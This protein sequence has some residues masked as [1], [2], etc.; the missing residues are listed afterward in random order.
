M[1]SI[2]TKTFAGVTSVTAILATTIVALDLPTLLN[3]TGLQVEGL[4]FALCVVPFL[5]ITTVFCFA[6]DLLNSPSEAE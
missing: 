1:T 2:H 6:V 4:R 3:F 5:A